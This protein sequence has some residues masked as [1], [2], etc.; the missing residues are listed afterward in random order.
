M[1]FKKFFKFLLLFGV[2]NFEFIEF[3][4]KFFVS[5]LKL[6]IDEFDFIDLFP[7]SF[8]LFFNFFIILLLFLLQCNFKLL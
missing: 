3:F 7:F 4:L 8:Y 1:C 5:E 6:V 2:L